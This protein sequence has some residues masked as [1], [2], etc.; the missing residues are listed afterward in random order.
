MALYDDPV[1][2][3]KQNAKVFFGVVAGNPSVSSTVRLPTHGSG[4]VF[5]SENAAFTFG[6]A[7]AL[8]N[9]L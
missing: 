2:I 4:G 8:P 5:L 6:N 9:V 3:S 7:G 1:P